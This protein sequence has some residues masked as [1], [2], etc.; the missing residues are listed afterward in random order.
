ML[1]RHYGSKKPGSRGE[2]R[3]RLRAKTAARGWPVFQ[4]HGQD[5]GRSF[6]A[7][8]LKKMRM[9]GIFSQGRLARPHS[10]PT[11]GAERSESDWP[12]SQWAKPRCGFRNGAGCGIR[13]DEREES[14]ESVV[15]G[16]I[17]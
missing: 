15:F 2:P 16:R 6:R 14:D 1:L 7:A 3:Q 13:S 8:P 5:G 11:L 9:N 10:E 12:A 4:R 17:G